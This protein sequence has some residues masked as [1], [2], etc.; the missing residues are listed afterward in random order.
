M[1][2]SGGGRGAACR[3]GFMSSFE[4]RH[5]QLSFQRSAVFMT[6]AA[7]VSGLHVS[8]VWMVAAYAALFAAGLGAGRRVHGGRERMFDHWVACAVAWDEL[9]PWLTF[10]AVFSLL[11]FAVS[12]LS[13]FGHWLEELNDPALSLERGLILMQDAFWAAQ[14]WGS[15]SFLLC[16]AMGPFAGAVCGTVDGFW[17]GTVRSRRGVTLG[18]ALPFG[19]S[20]SEWRCRERGWRQRYLRGSSEAA[21]R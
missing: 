13:I 2:V 14:Q 18:A 20:W 16:A 5:V 12:V 8:P 3:P 9:R 17:V 4:R 7:A 19:P 1:V 6:T 10:L 11:P 15:G 21:D